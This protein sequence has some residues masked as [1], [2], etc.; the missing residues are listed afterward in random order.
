M[1]LVDHQPEAVPA[2]CALLQDYLSVQP[3]ENVVITTDADTDA[4]AAD[5]LLAAAVMLGARPLVTKAPRLPV[6][7]A[8]ANPYISEAVASAAATRGV[9][10]DLTWPYMA[11]S[12]AHDHAM[13]TGEVR[14]CLAGDIDSRGLE[15]LFGQADLAAIAKMTV[16]FRALMAAS[17]GKSCRITCP[18]GT[19]FEFKIGKGSPKHNIFFVPG[20]LSIPLDVETV[21]GRIVLSS[22][23]HEYYTP[24]DNPLVL[25]VD[26]QI[27]GLEG[28]GADRLIMDR[29]LRRANNGS[30]GQIIHL[31]VGVHPAA[32]WTG[33]SFIEDM[34]ACGNNA[35]GF[36]V[37]FWL[38]G[39]GENHPDGIVRSQSISIDGEPIVSNGIF[40]AP[41]ALVAQSRVLAPNAA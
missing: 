10:I 14:Y 25:E 30:Y 5:A 41:A 24:L 11:G 19:D 32:R 21:R 9:W 7:G 28:E 16:D 4:V 6:Q 8:L 18:R 29:V 3:G 39:G 26:N 13:K 2:A 1:R 34:R 37:P 27:V 36:G 20:S 38:P 15:R 22:V 40:V 12:E 33:R 17:L 31:N 23:M 35:I